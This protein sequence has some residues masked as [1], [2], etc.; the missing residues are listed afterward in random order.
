MVLDNAKKLD[1]KVAL[2]TGGNSGI[3]LATAQLFVSH[4]AKVIV[5]ARSTET[6]EKAKEFGTLF[7]VVQCDVSDLN[8]LDKLFEHI[9]TKYNHLD[10]LFANAGIAEFVPTSLVDVASYDRIM[11]T[12]VKGVYFTVAKALPLLADGSS[13]ILNGSAVGETGVEGSSVY[14]ATK[15]ALRS[16]VR[17]WTVEIPPSKTRFNVVSPGLIETPI[18]GKLTSQLGAEQVEVFGQALIARTPA[19]RPGKPEEIAS[20]TLFLAS[21]DSTYICGANIAADGGFGQV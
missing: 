1:G 12:N 15:A 3:G 4:G 16:F 19:K 13:V 17:T 18:L 10:V 8:A 11:N 7:D 9:K 20:V 2:I 5:T 21:T 6:F 14:S